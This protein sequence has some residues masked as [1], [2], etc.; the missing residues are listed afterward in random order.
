MTLPLLVSPPKT[1]SSPTP[2][3]SVTRSPTRSSLT[4]STLL[5][6]PSSRPPSMR[7]SAGSTTRK[8]PPRRS[9]RRGR[10]SSRVLPTPS[11]RSS[12][13]VQVVLLVLARMVPASRKST[14]RLV[15]FS[16]LHRSF[17]H[18][19]PG[20][21]SQ[22]T[23]FFMLSCRHASIGRF[24]ADQARLIGILYITSIV[25]M[26]YTLSYNNVCALS[27]PPTSTFLYF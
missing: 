20:V 15:S 9:T 19:S 12:T 26:P 17:F 16:R 6:R 21:A 4:S 23:L 2:T 18:L 14:N 3:T 13:L 7:S 27:P 25:F 22:I 11:C 24:V 5:T 1:V 10:R 8:K